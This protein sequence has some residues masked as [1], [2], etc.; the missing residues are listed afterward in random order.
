MKI[1]EC[2]ANF[3]T[4]SDKKINEIINAMLSVPGITILDQEG[5]KDHNRCVISFVG[6]PQDIVVAAFK[7]TKK[8]ME[9][10]D[11][12]KHKGEH[13]RLGATDV[14]PFIPI[15]NVTMKE[16]VE[17]AK[18]LGKKVAKELFIPVYLYEEAATRSDRKNLANIRKGQFEALREEIKNNP[19]KIPDYG[20]SEIHPTAGATVIG[21]RPALIAYNVYLGTNNIEIAKK[22]AKWVR[23]SSGGLRYVKAMGFEITERNL[24]QVSMNMVNHEGTSLYR[25]FELIK[26]EADRWGV[27]I[28]ESEIVGLVPQSALTDAS[29]YYLKLVNFKRSQILELRLQ[30]SVTSKQNL[31]DLSLINFSEILA[32]AEPTPG[33]GSAAALSSTLGAALGSMTMHLTVGNKKFAQVD[34]QAQ[35]YLQQITK[36]QAILLEAVDRDSKAFNAVMTAFKMPKDTEENITLRSKAIQEG[37]KKAT[38]VPIETAKNS[39][40]ALEILKH[41]IT[42]GNP[43]TI[44]DVGVGALLLHAGLKGSLYNVQINL[45]SIKDHDFVHEIK[46]EIQKL[47]LDATNLLNKIKLKVEAAF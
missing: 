21:A 29:E 25:V 44:S 34:Q 26:I 24:V 35:K 41:I 19:D 12:T 13:P 10:I 20:P 2:V 17:L 9:L 45:S 11:L 5:D 23:H 22:I 38:L 30:E 6:G 14:I 16:C 28:V 15:S 40:S 32:S 43:N 18:Q 3:S 4:S 46:N 7:G 47:D 36:V 27:P 8:A 31:I 39:F 37:Y 42:I 1:V 33:G